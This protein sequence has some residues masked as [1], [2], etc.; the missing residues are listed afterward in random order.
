MVFTELSEKCPPG[1]GLKT[2]RCYH[3]IA[4]NIYNLLSSGHYQK[5]CNNITNNNSLLVPGF[6]TDLNRN[7]SN[8][9]I[10]TVKQR[11]DNTP[12]S[13]NVNTR[14]KILD[15]LD[16]TT[17]TDPPLIKDTTTQ[18]DTPFI[19]DITTQTKNPPFIKDMSTQTR[20]SPFIDMS[21]QTTNTPIIKDMST[22]TRKFLKPK[23]IKPKTT[24][25]I[26]PKTFPKI[27]TNEI[28]GEYTPE[29][30]NI[31]KKDRGIFTNNTKDNNIDSIQQPSQINSKAI[32]KKNHI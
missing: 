21:T 19:K 2:F 20:D 8:N 10:E 30:I 6:E 3:L 18:T 31:I 16:I 29:N 15:P 27:K 32:I 1:D 4:D 12:T 28:I 9:R 14:L 26:K 17:Q 7:V 11:D 25:K 22:Q 23:Q 5:S 13:S 24:P